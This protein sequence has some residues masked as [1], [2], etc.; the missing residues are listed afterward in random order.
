MPKH[1]RL[2]L[3]RDNPDA[4]DH[5]S[6]A[7]LN[8]ARDTAVKNRLSDCAPRGNLQMN[9]KHS[10][11]FPAAETESERQRL[12]EYI[13][14][15]LVALGFEAVRSPDVVELTE[16]PRGLLA[17]YR[18]KSRLLSE[19]RCLAD[20]R[21]EDFLAKHL[22][23]LDL[24]APLRLP[25]RPFI[26]DRHGIAR[27]LSLPAGGD[28][29]ESELVSSYRLHNGVLHNPLHDRRTTE[30]TFH[31]VEDGLPI[32]DD[33]RAVPRLTFARMFLQAVNPPRHLL[34]LP[35]TSDFSKPAET[36]VSLLLRPLVCP[37]VPR[38][39]AS[40]SMEVRFFAPG[41]LV[42]NLDFVES[43][44]GNAGDP[45]I[46]ENDSALDV[47]HWTGHTGCVILAPHLLNF[48]KRDL[49][50]PDYESASE[51]QRR[52]G[53]CYRSPDE[54]YNNGQPFKICCRTAD[55]VIVTLI[56]DNYFGYCK[57]EV[58]T[59][60]SYA[61]NLFGN[62]EE[63]HA[64]GTMA[65]PSYDLGEEFRVN[66]RRYNGRTFD[67]VARD[68]GA[69]M[70]I[71]PEGYGIDRQFP[72]LIYIPE[73][74]R[75]NLS[76][77]QISWTRDGEQHAIPL[78]P[79]KVYMAPSGYKIR[80]EK[81]PSTPG[82]RL[83]GT[84]AE[85]TFCH[86]PCTVSGGGK[87]EI[88]KSLADYMHYGPI[89]VADIEQ[90]LDQVEQVFNFDFSTRYRTEYRN[91]KNSLPILHPD[92]KLGS[93]VKLLKPSSYYTDEYNAW[94][95]Q[96]P[97]YILA[98][99]FIIKRFHRGGLDADWRESF[100]VDIINGFP[101]HELNYREHKLIGSYIRVGLMAKQAWRTFK[102]RQDFIA[103]AKTQ[104]EDDITSSVVVPAGRL[105]SMNPIL[106][107][108][109]YKFAV[110]CEYRL[111]Q[112]PDDAIHRGLDKQ[113]ERDLSRRHNFISN[114]EPMTAAQVTDMTR[115]VVDFDAFSEPM[116]QM[117]RSVAEKGTGYVVCSA[118]PR[119]IDGKPTKNP[120]YLQDR[121][122]LVQ[123]FNYYVA[124][125]GARLFRG[126]PLDQWVPTPVDAVLSGRRNNPPDRARG[127]R[128]LAVYGPIH[129]Q[130]LPELFMEYLSSLTGKSPSTT[131]AGTERALTKGPFNALL[132]AADLN[133]ALVSYLLTG[134]G[135][136]STAAGHIGPNVQVDHDISL[137][138]P[139]VWCRM[140][141][142]ERDPQRL[143]DE[144]MLERIRDFEYEGRTIPAS[145][146]GYRITPQFVRTFLS[147]IFD[148]P[149][150]VFDEAILR[151]ETQ[152][153]EAYVDGIEH[154]VQAQQKVAREYFADGSIDQVCPPL[155]ALLHIMVHGDYEGMT[156]DAPEFRQ[157]FTRDSLLDS[158][159]YQAR[160]RT[161]QQRDLA[162]WDR[163]CRSLENYQSE[164]SDAGELARLKIADRL[165]L[166]R[167]ERN[168][169]ADP[170]YVESL[171]GM[172]GADPLGEI[173]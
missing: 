9:M 156:I 24:P 96:I 153:L 5:F 38:V 81:H 14:L 160:L 135:G 93:T 99:V 165:E 148:N 114:F 76:E 11:G 144:G 90:D 65:Y 69:L 74:S 59:Q 84:L 10:I 91:K 67:D 98:L 25:N 108:D 83:V 57:K 72:D 16:V 66:S 95:Q 32:P 49:G 129:Y 150:R 112:R 47:E 115:Y 139:E 97:N 7:P 172:L 145:R 109:S 94:L 44:F 169:V 92:R 45:F 64:G 20:Q 127:I 154:I 140:E 13:N 3:P 173:E 146:L 137:L 80:M 131:G 104:T 55:G 4:T 26:L 143:I 54:M 125:R 19:Y 121:P 85:G 164:V 128:P 12:L 50:L 40:K 41:N 60:I 48:T 105:A 87:S 149:D 133:N 171:V 168:R 159:W 63:E 42:S 116:Q 161:K 8:A 56:A 126:V 27:E 102:T 6:T 151:P 162:L 22:G 113:T 166:A 138:I 46:P 61:A 142:H 152:D 35:Y 119:Q 120:R 2:P 103:A 89:F 31:I 110:N 157:M 124:E 122:D 77:Q 53:M 73:D 100:S 36:F 106:Q 136:F 29:F 58:K 1:R 117:L 18:Q 79:S 101:G 158:D 37:E 170:T 70:D 86:K 43:I 107:A 88:S 132:P 39:T 141:P 123:P 17:N 155:K 147:R 52:D 111:F 134:M 15:Q 78:L 30:A 51:R 167:S 28:V 75:A 21:I 118:N 71:Q 23:D 82:W 33:K 68:Y 130:D 34:E 62:C 163:H